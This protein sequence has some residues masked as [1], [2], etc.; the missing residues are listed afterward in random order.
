MH[1]DKLVAGWLQGM[2]PQGILQSVKATG[3]ARRRAVIGR[4]DITDTPGLRR[5][6]RG[7]LEEEGDKE[8]A[9]ADSRVAFHAHLGAVSS[10]TIGALLHAAHLAEGD[11]RSPGCAGFS[12]ARTATMRVAARGTVLEA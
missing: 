11:T 9:C 7:W 6:A 8:V 5:T 1:Q 4:R 3:C 12:S 10:F 2:L